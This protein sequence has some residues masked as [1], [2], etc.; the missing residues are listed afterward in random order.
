MFPPDQIPPIS[1][2]VRGPKSLALSG[3]VADGTILGEYTAPVYVEWAREQIVIGQKEVSRDGAQSAHRLSVFAFTCVDSQPSNA[4][5]QLRPLVASAI[6]YGKIDTQIAPMG[7]M[8]KVHE[9]L[10]NG[11]KQHLEEEMPDEWVDRLCIVGTPEQCVMAIRRLVDAG[12]HT[13]VLVP[14]P[15]K[16]MD[17]LEKFAHHLP[18]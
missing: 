9:Y 12:A 18:P 11:G 3:R 8:P 5:Q 2:G 1:L 7:I 14:L 16:G 17:E 15:D 13:V 10:E 4:R 6:A